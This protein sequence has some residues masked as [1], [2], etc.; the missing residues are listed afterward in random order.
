MNSRLTV[1]PPYVFIDSRRWHLYRTDVRFGKLPLHQDRAVL[2]RNRARLRKLSR[3]AL[4]RLEWMIYYERHARDAG[5]TAR[6]YG[7]S[8]KTFWKW[9]KRFNERDLSTL[10]NRCPNPRK[11]VGRVVAPMPGRLEGCL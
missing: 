11:D 1:R 5:L 8:G 7:I 4:A 3:G 6:H 2:W 9:R 10:V